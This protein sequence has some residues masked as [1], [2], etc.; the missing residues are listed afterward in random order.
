MLSKIKYRVLGTHKVKALSLVEKG[1][2]G[3]RRLSLDLAGK[4]TPVTHLVRG[5]LPRATLEVLTPREGVAL[6]GVPPPLY[7]PVAW[8]CLWAGQLTGSVGMVITD[9]AKTE[10]WVKGAFPRLKEKVVVVQE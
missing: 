10:G 7:R 9:N 1:W 5:S 4:G 8:L 2:A 6:V 3:A